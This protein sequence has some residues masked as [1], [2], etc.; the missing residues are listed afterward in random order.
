MVGCGADTDANELLKSLIGDDEDF[1]IPLPNYKDDPRYSLPDESTVGKDAPV[2]RLTNTDLTE[3]KL[4]GKG[5]F[6]VLMAALNV[7]L[8]REMEANR[9]SGA[10]YTKAY[11]ALTEAALA[12]GTS[13]LLQREASYWQSV[14]AQLQ[15]Q[16]AEVGL[17]TARVQMEAEK[18][19]L[20]TLRLEALGSK[21]RYAREKLELSN[22]NV[23]F[24]ISKF[25][26]DE[27]LPKQKE[28]LDQQVLTAVEELDGTKAR[29]AMVRE[30]I[31]SVVNDNSLFPTKKL[32]TEA[33]LAGRNAQNDNTVKQGTLLDN[34]IN[35]NDQQVA[36]LDKQI[37][38]AGKQNLLLDKQA[39][40]AD[41]DIT[42]FPTQKLLL[43]SEL[44]QQK[45][46]TTNV[47]KQGQLLDAEISQAPLKTD[48]LTKQITGIQ[49]ENSIKLK[50][51][52]VMQGELDML[53]AK[54]TLLNKQVDQITA[55]IALSGAQVAQ[56]G[57][58]SDYVR[59]QIEQIVEELKLQ[60]YKMTLMQEQA[61]SARAQT[62]DSRTD[63]TPV[64]GSV[65]KQKELYSQQ[66]TS[67]KRD[68]EM[69]AAKVFID[70]W[71][72]MKTIDEGLAPPTG[73][74]NTNLDVILTKLKANNNL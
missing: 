24:C 14:N 49:N 61:E 57:A 33:E 19:K 29:T 31:K 52:D 12:N 11:I 68:A 3:E 23:Q 7:H 45:A 72:T 67:Y 5:V 1:N 65:G 34:E 40:K 73:F 13:Y 6:D 8:Q 27:M 35:R 4:D 37:E 74:S 44:A 17:V 26:L 18:T 56:I 22:V 21:V 10:E 55:Q 43:E 25:N 16:I 36:M 2:A 28:L 66:I 63:G 15:A 20:A 32:I 51:I 48:M 64:S 42:L 62:L 58:Q 38:G 41:N 46:Q 47:G 50:Q 59:K 53:P 69:K 9:I 71:V 30:Q 60:P 70:A 39:T 54:K